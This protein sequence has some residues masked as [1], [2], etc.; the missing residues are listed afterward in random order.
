VLTDFDADVSENTG[1]VCGI[2]D[3]FEEFLCI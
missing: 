2:V 3:M 1:E